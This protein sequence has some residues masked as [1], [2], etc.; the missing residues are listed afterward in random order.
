MRIP[1]YT[2]TEGAILSDE[3]NA[4]VWE[5]KFVVI[6]E[7]VPWMAR[8]YESS[9]SRYKQPPLTYQ[10]SPSVRHEREHL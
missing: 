8:R 3:D 10:H 7:L 1:W 2:V 4:P 5:P 9:K 6:D